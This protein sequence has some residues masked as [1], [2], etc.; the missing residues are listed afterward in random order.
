[1]TDQPPEIVRPASARPRGQPVA[2]VE[3]EP[4]T[5]AELAAI[6]RSLVDLP[7]F[8]G[9]EVRPVSKL[10]ATLALLPGRG[11]GYNFAGCAR[12][13]AAEVTSRL[14]ALA[15]AMQAAREWP[16]VLVADGVTKPLE[17][18]AELHAAGWV[19][20]E[21]ERIMWTRTAPGVPHLDAALRLEAVTSRTAAAYEVLERDIFGLP[22]DFAPQ[23]AAGL[24]DS[25]SAG[26]LRAF[27]VRVDGAAVATARLAAGDM[28]A[29][30]FGVGVVPEQRRRG[31]GSLVT[32]VATRAGLAA[33]NKL[34]WLSVSESNDAAM[35]VYRQ[36]GFQPAFEWSRWV[37]SAA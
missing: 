11:P 25:L 2:A 30:I 20:I 17:L 32:A 37:I 26:S 6:E 12:W 29:G 7:R 10:A 23:R 16:A 4:P 9:A 5:D 27:I 18:P 34:V 8:S 36:L 19:E 28:V 14:A 35:R 22:A 31:L 21:R 15:E 3:Q 33:G 24:S 13:S 1:V